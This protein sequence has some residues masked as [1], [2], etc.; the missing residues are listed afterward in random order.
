VAERVCGR[1]DAVIASLGGWWAGPRIIDIALPE[2]DAVMDEMLRTHVVFARTFIPMLRE[3]G[4]GRYIGIGG[5]AAYV[6]IPHSAPVSVAGAAQLML[7]RALHAENEDPALDILELVIDGPVRTRDVDHAG[8]EWIGLDQIGPVVA[9]L[10]ERGETE[11][12]LVS[13]DGPIVTL[14][15][16]P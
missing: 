11:S 9:D 6:P 13:T 10:V 12:E 14:R 8:P 5:G 3:G 4:G 2:W 7:T 15:P 16:H 1:F